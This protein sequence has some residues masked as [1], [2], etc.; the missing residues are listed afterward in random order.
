MKNKILT[1]IIGVLV[2]AII[3][4]AGFLIYE[5]VNN[6][7]NSMPSGERPQMMEGE[8]GKTPPE[9]PDGEQEQSNGT[10]SEMPSKPN[11]SSENNS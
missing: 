8:N 4:T 5:K 10:P 9:K 3:T 6:N 11:S 2:G 1:F 7:S